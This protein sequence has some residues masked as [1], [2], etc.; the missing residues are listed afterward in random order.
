MLVEVRED[1]RATPVFVPR[2]GIR[3][4]RC[5]PAF[6]TRDGMLNMDG[7]ED[8]ESFAHAPA[9]YRGRVAPQLERMLGHAR[10]TRESAGPQAAPAREYPPEQ[11]P[12]PM[13]RGT[14]PRTVCVKQVLNDVAG[15]VER[16][17]SVGIDKVRKLFSPL[18]SHPGPITAAALWAGKNERIEPESRQR[19][20]NPT[21]KRTS[22]KFV[23]QESLFGTPCFDYP[24]RADCPPSTGSSTPVIKRASSDARKSA[25]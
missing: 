18:R 5:H 13:R 23:E 15:F 20:P 21:A 8:A 3:E 14:P 4:T 24:I 17:P 22:L 7:F 6:E 25:A 16:G 1:R 9:R 19:I 10:G 11:S 12:R 2:I